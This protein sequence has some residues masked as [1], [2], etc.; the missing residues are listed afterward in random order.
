MHRGGRIG[1]EYHVHSALDEFGYV[2]GQPRKLR[3]KFKID[4]YVLTNDQAL[5]GEAPSEI[6][7]RKR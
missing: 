3:R 6:G 4:R 5:I 1:N 2:C 7:Y